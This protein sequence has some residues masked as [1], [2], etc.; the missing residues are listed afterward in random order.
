MPVLFPRNSCDG[1]CVDRGESRLR[2]MY[3][4]IPNRPASRHRGIAWNNKQP[5]PVSIGDGSGCGVMLFNSRGG[6]R[7]RDPGIMSAVL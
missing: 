7:T 5:D 1:A 4:C 3:R 2:A 6:T